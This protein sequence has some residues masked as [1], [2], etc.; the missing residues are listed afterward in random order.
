V[1]A[2][3]RRKSEAIGTTLWSNKVRLNWNAIWP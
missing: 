2:Y 1:E 3:M